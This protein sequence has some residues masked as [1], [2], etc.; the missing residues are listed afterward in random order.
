MLGLKI[1]T[2][3][4][5]KKESYLSISKKDNKLILANPEFANVLVSTNDLFS[6]SML[7]SQL[8]TP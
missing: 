8:P 5:F 2:K 4:I 7:D 3:G 1:H 6:I